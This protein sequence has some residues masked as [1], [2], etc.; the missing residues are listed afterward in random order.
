M[1]YVQVQLR[2]VLSALR[3][4]FQS[5]DMRSAVIKHDASWVSLLTV[6]RVSARSVEEIRQRHQHLSVN[7]PAIQAGRFRVLFE[8]ALFSEIDKLLSNLANGFLNIEGERIAL[9]EAVS[10]DQGRGQVSRWKGFVRPWSQ[11]T[12]PSITYSFGT[13]SLSFQDPDIAGAVIRNGWPSVES[14]VANLLEIEKEDLYRTSVALFI[15]IEMP[16]QMQVISA[17]NGRF[18]IAVKAE[19]SLND[20][21]LY[22]SEKSASGESS[23]ELGLSRIGEENGFTLWRTKD[24]Q[25]LANAD[26]DFS[27]WLSHDNLPVI[28]VLTGR[29]K[30]FLPF[31]DNR[32]TLPSPYPLK[33]QASETRRKDKIFISHINEEA[34]LAI[35]LKKWIE[36]AFF[37]HCEVF[38]SSHP[39]D[40]PAGTK[41]L[42]T[43]STALESAN[44]LI[45]LCSMSSI[46][47]PWINFESGCCWNRGIPIMPV[48][49]SGLRRNNLPPPLSSFQALEVDDDMFSQNLIHAVGTHLSI[50]PNEE[51]DFLRMNS[52][53]VQ[54]SI[55]RQIHTGKAR[56]LR[57]QPAD[58]TLELARALDQQESRKRMERI[59]RHIRPSPLKIEF[60]GE[61]S[62][63]WVER[64]HPALPVQ[65][66]RHK[67]YGVVIHNSAIHDVDNVSVELERI[68]DLSDHNSAEKTT[69]PYLG[70]KLLF[71]R[72]GMNTMK[73]SPDLRDRVRLISHG[74][75]ILTGNSFQIEGNDNYFID[76]QHQHRI[77]LKV[78]GDGV[79]PSKSSFIVQLDE[80]GIF[81]MTRENNE[82]S[83]S[84]PQGE[85]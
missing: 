18:A 23:K 20:L 50:K 19:H 71:E 8:A 80:K 63:E 9:P 15:T 28:D 79:K 69:P 22:W 66:V 76:A 44:I 58:G 47:R 83:L 5:L 74:Q 2:E 21:T 38:V 24:L 67:V 29:Y 45:V 32:K 33:D 73:F 52:E 12:W 3:D 41:W 10:A 14:A 16:A 82:R 30:D 35:E 64:R 49:H 43:I 78:T 62:A 7:A 13:R 54:T 39:K 11:E 55:G 42:E 77:Y 26:D 56:V 31:A 53:L 46:A 65:Q 37:S 25:V 75:G 4:S 51:L 60:D 61:H 6:V 57:Q 40:L 81:R 70:H 17:P 1:T 34:P 59:V 72:N 85:E 36:Q 68:E 48:C 84:E 27:C